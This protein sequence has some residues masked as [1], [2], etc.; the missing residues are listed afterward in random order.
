[1]NYKFLPLYS[2][3]SKELFDVVVNKYSK[4]FDVSGYQLKHHPQ[5]DSFS[6]SKKFPIF[7]V[8]DGATLEPKLGE[9][10]P[11]PSGAFLV[12]DKFVKLM[13]K[14]CEKEYSHLNSNKLKQIFKKG[15]QEVK[16]I[17]KRYGRINSKLNYLD[18]DLFCATSA[19]GIIK[20]DELYWFT[21]ADSFVVIFNAKGKQKF[22][23]P[24]GWR[25]IQMPKK[26]EGKEKRIYIRRN[27]TALVDFW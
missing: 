20:N 24:N 27:W 1:M 10:Y 25:F 11:N 9:K 17:N 7:C 23:S 3:V 18:F 2:F 14:E 19:L 5:E 12:T 15:N 16:K 4:E 8:G 21:I 6:F 22:L 13:V 26:L